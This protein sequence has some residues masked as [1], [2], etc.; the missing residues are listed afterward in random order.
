MAALHVTSAFNK[1]SA[2]QRIRGR[3]VCGAASSHHPLSSC[4]IGDMYEICMIRVIRSRFYTE[5]LT[6][7]QDSRAFSF[8]SYENNVSATQAPLEAKHRYNVMSDQNRYIKIMVNQNLDFSG[9]TCKIR[10]F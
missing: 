9:H 10:Q 3:C 1:V 4:G 7:I 2:N 5:I 8:C 6:E